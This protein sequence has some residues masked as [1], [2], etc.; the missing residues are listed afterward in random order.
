MK[1]KKVQFL[2]CKNLKQDRFRAN[3]TKKCYNNTKTSRA[4]ENP[5]FCTLRLHTNLSTFISTFSISI[6]LFD[7]I[8]E[9]IFTQESIS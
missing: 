2:S 7:V 5:F 8:H 9:E 4:L 3:T 6:I 1:V